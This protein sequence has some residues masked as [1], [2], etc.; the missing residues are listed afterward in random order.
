M[1]K[2]NIM[3]YFSFLLFFAV[4]ISCDNDDSS[5]NIDKGNLMEMSDVLTDKESCLS[6][7]YLSLDTV[8]IFYWTLEDMYRF[9]AEPI[10]RENENSENVIMSRAATKTLYKYDT[11]K[12]RSGK[13]NV[14][15]KYYSKD[16]LEMGISPDMV[17]IVDFCEATISFRINSDQIARKTDSPKCGYKPGSVDPIRGYLLDEENGIVTLKTNLTHV[18]YDISGRSINRWSP[19]NP[20]NLEWNYLLGIFQ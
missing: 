14:K 8:G 15:T 11:L 17:Y 19:I 7:D 13:E 20:E 18:K 1:L 12:P 9:M 4:L 5:M 10:A 2:I 16:A 3:K 6:I